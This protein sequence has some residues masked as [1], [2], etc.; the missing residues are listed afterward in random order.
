MG[1]TENKVEN[2]GMFLATQNKHARHH[3][4]PRIDHKLTTFLP[5]PKTQKSQ[6]PLQKPH[7]PLQIFFSKLHNKF[8]P[9]RSYFSPKRR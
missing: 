3:K 7:S 2:S 6:N 1:K 8:D 9:I 5:S 4:T